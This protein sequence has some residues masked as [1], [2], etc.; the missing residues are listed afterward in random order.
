MDVIFI[1]STVPEAPTQINAVTRPET[2]AWARTGGYSILAF[3]YAHPKRAG[4][5]HRLGFEAGLEV[6]Q[7]LGKTE[8]SRNE[9]EQAKSTAGRT[10]APSHRLPG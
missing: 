9:R 1:L 2:P 10:E 8:T 5:P 4:S 3:A 6:V 7:E